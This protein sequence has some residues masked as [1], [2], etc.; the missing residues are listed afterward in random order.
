MDAPETRALVEADKALFT[1]LQG[2]ALPLTYVGSRVLLGFKPDQLR[3][4][5]SLALAGP[6]LSL[7]LAGL[8]A[9]VVAALAAAAAITLRSLRTLR[10]SDESR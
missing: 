1:Q 5:V 2:Q 8:F 3:E 10:K 7:P 9:L 4:A 6:R